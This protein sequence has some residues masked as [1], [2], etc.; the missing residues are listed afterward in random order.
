MLDGSCDCPRPAGATYP[1]CKEY[2][3][4]LMY[5]PPSGSRYGFPRPYLPKDKE[6]LGETL[7]R[8]GYPQKELDSITVDGEVKWVRFFGGGDGSP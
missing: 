8:D 3:K 5:D 7:L 1:M 4:P 2:E 6:S